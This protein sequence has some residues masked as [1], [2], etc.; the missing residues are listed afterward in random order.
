LPGRSSNF[1]NMN[2]TLSKILIGK[3]SLSFRR[4]TSWHLSAGT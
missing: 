1:E 4:N 3:N 2:A